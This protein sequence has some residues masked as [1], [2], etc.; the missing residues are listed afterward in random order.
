L[1][2]WIAAITRLSGFL[3]GLAAFAIAVLVSCE[4]IARTFFATT[5]GWVNDVSEYMMGFIAF[6]GA[7]YALAEGAHVGVDLV[8]TRVPPAVRRVLAWIADV[9]VLAIVALLCWLSAQFWWE[10][11]ETGERSWG[12]F[13]IEL[14]VPY[15]FFMLGMFWLLVVHLVEMVN[16]R[17]ASAA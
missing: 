5:T 16:R 6:G 15:S 7:A 3:V 13:T 1:L 12:L 2:R 17:R 9:A 8:V 14:W 4:V 11:F 10:A